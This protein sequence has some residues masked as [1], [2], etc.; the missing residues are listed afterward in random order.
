MPDEIL[1]QNVNN[2]APDLVDDITTWKANTVSREDFERVQSERDKFARALMRGEQLEVEAPEKPDVNQL[3]IDLFTEDV[4]K[5]TD[6]EIAEKT[7]QLR[8]AILDEGGIDPFVP[9]GQQTAPEE[10]DFATA[11]RVADVLKE[12]IDISNGNNAIFLAQLQS[13]MIDSN[14]TPNRAARR[15]R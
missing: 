4:Q 9:F 11:Q 2:E 13:R 6:V 8:Q 15:S 12:C 7:L 10:S 14:P 1:E 3:R 5:Y